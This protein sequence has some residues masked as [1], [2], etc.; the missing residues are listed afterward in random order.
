MEFCIYFAIVL[1]EQI[2]GLQM[3]SVNKVH[4]GLVCRIKPG[5]GRYKYLI[6]ILKDE[7]KK[8]GPVW[9]HCSF[10]FNLCKF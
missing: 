6:Q 3:S 5:D 1:P 8:H 7:A 4:N 9:K 10:Y 2:G